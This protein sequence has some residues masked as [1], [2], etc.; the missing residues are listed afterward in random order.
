MKTYSEDEARKML[1][2]QLQDWAVNDKA[3]HKEFKFSTFIE[4]FS[5]MTAIALEAEKM[6]HH[7]DWSNSYNKVKI[8]LTTHDKGGITEKD[9][10]LAEFADKCVAS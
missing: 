6:D 7:P 1:K 8:S 3:L 2:E 10:K 9:F 5:F 4:A